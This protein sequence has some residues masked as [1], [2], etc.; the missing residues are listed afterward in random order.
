MS[1][2]LLIIVLTCLI[3]SCASVYY[4]N[5]INSTF[6]DKKGETNL[7][8]ALSFTSINIQAST[9][10]NDHLR[11]TGGINCWGWNVTLGDASSGESGLQSQLLAGYYSRLNDLVFFEGYSGIGVNQAHEDLFGQGIL[12]TSL[13]LGSD[14]P[15]FVISIRAN[16]LSNSIFAGR[17]KVNEHY[18]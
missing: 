12:Q 16:Y 11:L 3:S 17:I 15:M 8:A 2:L 13:G 10:V 7:G 5:H 9:A 6:I 14:S 4:P 18:K 1:R